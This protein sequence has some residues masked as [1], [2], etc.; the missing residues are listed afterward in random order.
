MSDR[1]ERLIGRAKRGNLF[2][3]EGE[4]AKPWVPPTEKNSIK[5]DA[6]DR[7]AWEY[8]AD[9]LP[10]IGEQV[11]DLEKD[12]PTSPV[13]YEDLF[14]MLNKG[15][16]RMIDP[17]GIEPMYRPQWAIVKGMDEAEDLQHVRKHTR[18]DEYTTGV[19]IATMKDR[20][21]KAFEDLQDALD[22]MAAAEQL[23][24]EML[25]AAQEAMQNGQGQEQAADGLEKAMQGLAKAQGDAQAKGE[26]LSEA[27]GRGLSDAK[28]EL[29]RQADAASA[30]GVEDGDL[31]RMSFEERQA[32]VGRLDGDKMK[33]LADLVGQFREHADAERRRKVTRSPA[34]IYDVEIGNDLSKITASELTHMAIPELEDLFWLRYAKQELVQWKVRGN[35]HAGRGPILV[36]CDESGSMGCG[37]DEAGNTREAW[38][39]AVSL[40]LADQAKR[41]KRD[42]HYIGFSSHGQV[43]HTSFEKGDANVADVTG[44]V[45]HFFGGGTSYERPLT[46][47]MGICREYAEKGMRR[48]DVVFITDDECHVDD[49]FIAR[50]KADCQDLDVQCYGI[51][52]GARSDDGWKSAMSSLC[53]Q[54]INVNNLT[55]KA[56]D[57]DSLWRFI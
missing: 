4:A 18:Y 28:K 2:T 47:A 23:L 57:V 38:S 3:E 12:F 54:I 29:D 8:L 37:L 6:F 7:R 25:K 55:A 56:S 41:G 9:Q 26:E 30:Y 17:Q 19:A 27:A 36:V 42:F 22:A 33:R 20:M 44:F 48:P 11:E 15:D 45:E 31:K 46:D 53:T 50:W 5:G 39:K 40:A 24:Q 34:E 1:L 21:R 43:W 32:L 35:D 10:F 13:A 51:R 52:V 14:R 49:E 16:P